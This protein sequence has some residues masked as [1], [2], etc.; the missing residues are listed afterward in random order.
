MFWSLLSIPVAA[1]VAM[2]VGMAWYSQ[3][4]FGK[5]W[6]KLM[7]LS[8]HDIALQKKSTK[9]TMT[10]GLSFIGLLIE[11]FVVRL[12]L[13]YVGVATIPQAIVM[14]SWIWLGFMAPVMLNA[15]LY[16]GK[17]QKLFWLDAGYQLVVVVLMAITVVL[18]S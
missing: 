3:A 9:M 18:L 17:N 15:V 4:M 11:A 5:Q 14:S 13:I 12:F 7:N 6:M 1:V 16:G 10:Y 8:G 2:V